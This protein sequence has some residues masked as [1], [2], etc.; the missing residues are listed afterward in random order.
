MALATTNRTRTGVVKEVTPGTT[1]ATPAWQTLRQTSNSLVGA[2]KTVQS[3]ELISDRQIGDLILVGKDIGG[4]IA[5]E[6]SVGSHD[7]LIEC[8]MFSLWNYSNERTNTPNAAG[9]TAVAATTY[10]VASPTALQPGTWQQGDVVY[11]QGFTNAANNKVFVA[12][13]ASSGTSIVHTGGTVEGAPPATARLK[14]IGV[15]ALT[16]ADVQATTVGGNALTSTTLNWINFGF[17]VGMW[18]KIG[19]ALAADATSFATAANNGFARVSAVTATRLSLDI[20]PAGFATDTAAGKTVRVY[21]GDY[22][23]NGVTGVPLSI[24]NAYLDNGEF[25]YFKGMYAAQLQF[26]LEPQAIVKG[27]VSLLGMDSVVAGVTRFAGSTDFVPP[28]GVTDILNSSSNIGRLA[29]NGAPITAGPN[30]VLQASIQIANNLRAQPAVGSLGAIGVGAGRCEVTGT[31]NTYFGD[32]TI[33]AKALA[34]TGTSFDCV[35][36]DAAGNA[37]L[38]D[39]PRIKLSSAQA[40]VGGQDQDI[41]V[42]CGFQAL[43]HATLGYTIHMQVFEQLL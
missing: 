11:A 37:V 39:L 38:I 2:P 30:Y 23:R 7:S 24:E 21:M 15:Q 10:T 5:F 35:V 18:V 3:E 9:I 43:K 42:E 41:T 20:V 28:S 40:P 1:P 26:Q 33:L 6:Y 8:A 13:A 4:D 14:K 36:K 22:I 29:E 34:A 27:A 17:V 31:L 19:T 12:G 25:Q 32:S 16:A